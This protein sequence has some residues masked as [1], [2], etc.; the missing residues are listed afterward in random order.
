MTER[1]MRR[2]K[3]M[4]PQEECQRIL[5]D[6]KVA[7]WAV[8]G[9]DGYPYAVP[10][11]YVFF[12]GDI[13]IHSALQGHKI[14][15][16]KRNPKCSVC[17]VDRD[18]VVPEKFTSYFRSVISF[19]KAEIVESEPDKIDALQRLC[20]KYC[21]GIDSR[22]EIEKFLKAVAIIRIRLEQTTGKEAI[23]LVREKE[24]NCEI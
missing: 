21:P 12:N 10:V 16:I 9:D 7:V 13:F 17:I 14:D 6:G 22:Q 4:L 1:K 11:N 18:E 20:E 19:G 23:E 24:N 8:A 15:A 2:F 3:Q 5:R